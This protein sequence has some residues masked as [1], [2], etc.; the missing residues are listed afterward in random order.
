[1]LMNQPQLEE[2]SE[3][4]DETC[5]ESPM[6]MLWMTSCIHGHNLSGDFRDGTL[7]E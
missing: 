5:L 1:M 7:Q 6:E 2:S 4:Y 3:E